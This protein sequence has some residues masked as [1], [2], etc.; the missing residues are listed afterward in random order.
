MFM[1]YERYIVSG[2]YMR[3]DGRMHV[4]MCN[5][6][7]GQRTTVSYPKFLLEVHN[8]AY[9]EENETIDHIDGDV[10]NNSID[11][12]K[13]IK[14]TEHC[15]ID[16]FRL[17]EKMDFICPW[18]KKSFSLF[19]SHLSNAVSNSKRRA[20]PFCSKYCAGKYGS[21]VQNGQMDLIE[22]SNINPDYTNRKGI[23]AGFRNKMA[24]GP[25][26]NLYCT[27]D[28]CKEFF[29]RNKKKKKIKNTIK[30]GNCKEPIPETSC[31]VCKKV[32]KPKNRGGKYCSY[33]CAQKSAEKIL[34]PSKEELEKLVWGMPTS[35]LA[36]QLGVSD[37]A[38]DKR[39]KKLGIDKP[40]RGYWA[41]LKANQ[42]P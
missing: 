31:K 15:I 14:R 25:Y 13:I 42:A 32:F 9:L 19:G 39:C 28:L 30:S 41:K 23:G 29:D 4:C 21:A 24:Y 40:P 35:Q 7:T 1:V 6:D 27:C 36:K 12:L 17:P 26:K 10:K 18:C 34:W 33:A 11:N 8:N 5:V 3:K 20:G 2:P 22:P 37:K 38:I 16:V